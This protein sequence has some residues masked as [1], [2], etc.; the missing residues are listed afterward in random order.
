MGTE[1]VAKSVKAEEE[2]DIG[3]FLC[4]SP[5]AIIWRWASLGS[6]VASQEACSHSDGLVPHP[7]PHY[8]SPHRYV[9]FFMNHF[10]II[11][12]STPI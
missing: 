10:N 12:T 9:L 1:K 7:E 3:R 8:R 2:T 11:L 6:K 5:A 4:V